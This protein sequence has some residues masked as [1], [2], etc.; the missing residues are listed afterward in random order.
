MVRVLCLASCLSGGVSS[1]D[2][3]SNT[4]S[5]HC[6]FENSPTVL[7]NLSMGTSA[8]EITSMFKVQ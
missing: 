7:D 6:V 2:F 1:K 3:Q 4:H 5:F 8:M